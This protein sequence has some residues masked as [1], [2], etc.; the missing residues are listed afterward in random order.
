MIGADLDHRVAMSGLEPVQ[1]ERY[2]DVIVEIAA[3]RQRRPAAF[4]MAATISLTVVLP[5]L[6]ATPTIGSENCARQAAADC[7][8]AA[9][10]SRTTSCASARS[11]RDVDHCARGAGGFSG[12]D[13]IIGVEARATQRDEQ[14]ARLERARVGGHAS[15]GAIRT[16]EFGAAGACES[17]QSAIHGALPKRAA[18]AAATT[19][20]SLNVRRSL[21]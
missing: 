4:K 5:L 14:L 6:P 13:E 12:R 10:V 21:P 7:V 15:V 1:G 8:N 19:F 9:W 3:C 11:R 20:W 16:H 18:S 2:T 17:G